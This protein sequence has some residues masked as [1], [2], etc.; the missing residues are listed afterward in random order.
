MFD[1]IEKNFIIPQNFGTMAKTFYVKVA[2]SLKN[3]DEWYLKQGS[4]VTGVK[5]IAEGDEIREVERLIHDYPL[6]NGEKTHA[7]D[8]FKVRGTALIT[9]GTNEKV[10]ELHWY[11]CKDIGKVEYKQKIKPAGD[12][13]DA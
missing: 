7:K 1:D 8:W 13:Y 5:V 12:D 9:D 4:T 10:V 11:Q 3:Q 6:A 2:K